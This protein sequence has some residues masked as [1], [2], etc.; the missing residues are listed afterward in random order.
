M[1]PDSESRIRYRKGLWSRRF[2]FIAAAG[3]SILI[4]ALL[5]IPGS[6]IP[7][8]Q[9]WSFDKVGHAGLFFMLALLCL[10][11][12]RDKHS[13]VL[14]GVIVAGILLAPLSEIYQGLLPI[15]RIADPYDALADIAGFLAGMG[16]WLVASRAKNGESG[17]V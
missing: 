1:P 12:V 17:D 4:W 10:N 16:F 5:S 11:A 2:S 14:A 7:S 13:R 15:G 8:G 9:I 6:N 3:W